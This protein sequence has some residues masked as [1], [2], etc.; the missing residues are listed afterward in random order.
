M[1]KS[2][3]VKHGPPMGIP[4]PGRGPGPDGEGPIM[5][6][7]GPGPHMGPPKGAGPGSA[8]HIALMKRLHGE[9]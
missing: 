7:R 1:K 3:K 9:Y 8:K 4:R 6:G 5:P 2:K